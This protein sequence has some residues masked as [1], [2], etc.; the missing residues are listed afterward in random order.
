M[1]VSPLRT[2]P[3]CSARVLPSSNGRCPACQAA[4]GD[5]P[6]AVKAHADAP[7]RRLSSGAVERAQGPPLRGFA[8]SLAVSAFMLGSAAAGIAFFRGISAADPVLQA[9]WVGLLPAYGFAAG[10]SGRGRPVGAMALVIFGSAFAVLVGFTTTYSYRGAWS[11]GAGYM[12][13]S[14]AASFGLA[15]L[16][17]AGRQRFPI[18]AGIP[19]SMTTRILVV[20][21]VLCAV[22]AIGVLAYPFP[23]DVEA[24]NQQRGRQKS[25]GMLGASATTIGQTGYTDAADV[26]LTTRFMLGN[27]R[28]DYSSPTARDFAL[29]LLA[30]QPIR[31]QMRGPVLRL[32]GKRLEWETILFQPAQ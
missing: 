12:A 13:F 11:A 19:R 23:T 2:C 30:S 1:A 7:V 14:A 24:F 8:L 21:P 6:V 5:A 20:P 15:L 17:D 27:A 22:A 4:F 31:G 32:L 26:A 18:A 16:A 29:G 25:P 9:A 28:V 10:L 3:A